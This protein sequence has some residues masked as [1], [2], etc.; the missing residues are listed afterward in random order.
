MFK[1]LTLHYHLDSFLQ[2]I[3]Q[4]PNFPRYS[5]NPKTGVG[6]NIQHG[7]LRDP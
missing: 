5:N 6:L 3:A 4:T 2:N 7:N 1:Y